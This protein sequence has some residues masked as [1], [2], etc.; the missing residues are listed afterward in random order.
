MPAIHQFV[1]GF[2][3]GDAISNEALVLRGIFRSWGFESD[4][5]SEAR[6][7][8]PELRREA[9]D[10]AEA[11]AAC[12]PGDLAFLH[13]SIGSDVNDA[14]AA[15]RGR[16]ALLYH[17]I[18]P[19]QYFRG[20]QDETASRLERGLRQAAALAGRVG[21]ALADSAFN[22]RELE[23][24][25]FR[26]VRVLPL[27]LDLSPLRRKPDGRILRRAGD[28]LVNALFVGRAAPNKR[29]EDALCAFHYFQRYVEPN[30]RFIHVGSFAG[31]ERYYGLLQSFARKLELQNVWLNGPARPDEL[32]AFYR[33]ASLFLCMSEHEGFCIPILECMALDVP[34]IAYAAAAVPETMDGAGILFREKRY[35]VI[36]EILGLVARDARVREAVLAGQRAR[37]ARFERRDLESELRGHLQPLLGGRPP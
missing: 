23:Q 7:I 33:S 26:G 9:R 27:L 34:V 22:A 20:V 12:G 15:L 4:I 10:V 3:R 18:T 36:A 35:D 8:L 30:S 6:R 28:G 25:G 21:V 16:K 1:A 19:P 24:A 31:G 5:F 2:N 37:V 14:F 32:A 29:I 11:G 17:N 13:L